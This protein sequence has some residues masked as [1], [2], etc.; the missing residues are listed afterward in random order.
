MLKMQG[1]YL[2]DTSADKTQTT[3]NFKGSKLNFIHWQ[4]NVVQCDMQNI[5]SNVF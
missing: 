1:I 3:D 2:G 4:Q 5:P